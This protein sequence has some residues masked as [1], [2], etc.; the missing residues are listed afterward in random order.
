[1]MK[2]CCTYISKERLADPKQYHA[3]AKHVNT[4]NSMV[5]WKND[6]GNA[7]AILLAERGIKEAHITVTEVVDETGKKAAEILVKASFQK[8]ISTYT[9]SNW[10]PNPRP[11]ELPEVPEGNR[12]YSADVIYGPDIEENLMLETGGNVVQPVWITVTVSKNAIPGI[13]KGKIKIFLGNGEE[14]EL[15]LNIRVLNLILKETED[16]YLNLWQYPYAS[17]D[18]YHVTPFSD[19]HLSIMKNQ[20]K[21]Y[22]E[23]GGKTGTASI[24]EEPWYHQ[25][26]CEYPSMVKW[27]KE[28]KTWKFDYHDF[29]KWAEFLFREVKVSYIECYSIVPWEN[30]L[31]YTQ[32]GEE[33]VQKAA[34]GTQI[35]KNAWESFL[36][37][38]V[39]HLEQ[40]GWFERIILAMDER[41]MTEME[42]ALGLIESIQNEKGKSLK[43]GGAVEHYNKEI[44]DRL[45]TVTPH[46]SSIQ[47]D[48]IPLS[49][50]RDVT[51]KRRAQGKLTSIY[52]MIGDYPGIFS[53]SDPGEAAWTIWYAESCGTDGF[54]KWAYDAW[55]E[56]PLEDNAH[57]Y[58]EA[59]D[60]FF[61][62]PGEYE[63]ENTR[64]RMSP[65]FQVMA[66][67]ISDV[68]KLRQMKRENKEYEERIASLLT[69]VKP[70]YGTGVS[71]GIGTAGFR[72]AEEQIKAQLEQEVKRLHQETVGLALEYAGAKNTEVR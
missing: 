63:G 49:L 1:M 72:T 36:K 60:M 71:N 52:S 8:Y 45:F 53:M 30:I 57:P 47:E 51:V 37:D 42:T 46:I 13:Y 24:V 67:A 58:F 38:F 31:R 23:N 20:M 7:A 32:D 41:P 59:G 39:K 27:K 70:F 64:V 12:S 5:L 28:G 3:Y 40:K 29:D 33:K 56:K 25:T 11:F 62:Y 68:R 14:L 35:W 6:R 55:C 2:A 50:F 43:V 34:P 44:W 22:I 69:S 15:I 18:Y 48:K 26:Y 66:E 19:E 4:E 9:G 21:P 54:L 10:I 17:A 65:R 61:V 16:Y